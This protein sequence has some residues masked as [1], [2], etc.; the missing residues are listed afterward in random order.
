MRLLVTGGSGF[1]GT[2]LCEDLL[3][4]DLEI[5]NLD[6]R[7]PNIAHHKEFFH[8][9]DILDQVAL[10]SFFHDF[11]PEVVVHL[12]AE[13]NT[14][15][16][17][18]SYFKTNTEGTRNVINAINGTESVRLFVNTSTQY[19]YRNPDRPLPSDDLDYMPHTTYGYSKMIA[20]VLTRNLLKPEIASVTIRP[21]NIWGPWHMRYPL[22]LW[23]FLRK[24]LYV[25]PVGGEIVYKS[26]GYVKNVTHQIIGMIEN[27]PANGRNFTYYVGDLPVDSFVFINDFSMMMTGRPIRRINKSLMKSLAEIGTVM[28]SVGIKF[29]LYNQRYQNMILS[30]AA[31]I[32][33][34][35]DHFGLYS[36]DTHKNIHETLVWL[37][38]PAK[39]FFSYWNSFKYPII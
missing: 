4:K 12:A 9:C 22:E 28:R 27:P 30:E 17:R 11:K 39:E 16:E 36:A 26:Y 23:K 10:N 20:E 29:P 5:I 2:N 24:E 25:Y 32:Q 7:S 1:I 14:A 35:I 33:N 31:P 3:C 15:L 37:S 6:I 21:T 18:L 8:C 19:V 13:T 34:T 38:G